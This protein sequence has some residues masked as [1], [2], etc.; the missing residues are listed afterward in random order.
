MIP[1]KVYELRT[2]K[3]VAETSVE[4]GGASCPQRL[5]YTYYMTDLGPPSEVYVEASD[6]DVHAAFRSLIIP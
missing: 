3:L 5:S 4:I 6:A 1:L 2:A